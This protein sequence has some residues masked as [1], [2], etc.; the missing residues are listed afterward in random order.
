MGRDERSKMTFIGSVD[1]AF[2]Q[3]VVQG[4]M[5]RLGYSLDGTH[6]FILLVIRIAVG[7]LFQWPTAFIIK[8]QMFTFFQRDNTNTC[9]L[10]KILGLPCN[11]GLGLSRSF[12]L[13]DRSSN[14]PHVFTK[15]SIPHSSYFVKSA[16][17]KNA[18]FCSIL[19]KF[20]F[21]YFVKNCLTSSSDINFFPFSFR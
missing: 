16:R 18:I 11:P 20:V 12:I 13:N 9:F 7:L 14:P 17:D 4:R 21:H 5:I 2:G 15:T 10:P 19:D 1:L 3:K 6:R 8:K